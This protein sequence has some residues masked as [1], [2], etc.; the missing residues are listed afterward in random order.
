MPAYNA[1][2]FIR[3]SIDSILNQ[4]YA[5][6]ELL[7]ADDCSTDNTRS[8][9]ESYTDPRIKLHHNTENSGYLKTCNKLLALCQGEYLSFMDADD[10]SSIDRFAVQLKALQDNPEYAVCGCNLLY[11]SDAGKEL[12][13]SNF[14]ENSD[15]IRKYMLKGEFHY[16]PNTFLFTREV[17]QKAGFYHPYFDRIGAED[18]YWTAVII[19]KFKIINL[20]Q[21]LYY[22]RFNPDSI[23]GDLSDNP[24]KLYSS[25]VVKRLIEQRNATGTDDLEQ[26][27]I[28]DLDAFVA[29]LTEEFVKDNSVYL[30]TLAQRSFNNG[31]KSKAINYIWRAIKKKPFN[32]AYY[33]D[34]LYM[35]RTKA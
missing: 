12:Y 22:Y 25:N 4:T 15:E 33:R 14:V 30:K 23:S 13:C 26:G 7:I 18:Y 16:S 24:K 29:K 17:G 11:V 32:M 19:D 34:L 6:I 21:A 8:V 28:A 1:E 20:P 5:N 35:M 2:K 31:D 27:R 9:I 10:Y 3:T